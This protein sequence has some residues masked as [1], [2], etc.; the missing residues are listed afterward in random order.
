MPSQFNSGFD[1]ATRDS[2]IFVVPTFDSSAN[3]VA[4]AAPCILVKWPT[5]GTV[6]FNAA[7]ITTNS[8][9]LGTFH[10]NVG[11]TVLLNLSQMH[12]MM[13]ILGLNNALYGDFFVS[14]TSNTKRA[15]SAVTTSISGRD[16]IISP[17]V[18]SY[19]Q[20]YFSCAD[21]VTGGQL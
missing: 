12:E 10:S 16:Y 21:G 13:H 6:T 15:T 17:S 19:V 8:S 2:T 5:Y 11:V 4:A 3:Y 18:L 7:F 14:F 9:E 1:V 20:T